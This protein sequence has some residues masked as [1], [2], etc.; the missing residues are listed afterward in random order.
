[1]VKTQTFAKEIFFSPARKQSP[2]VNLHV[3]KR[4]FS[5]LYAKTRAAGKL[6]FV[7]LDQNFEFSGQ[8]QFYDRVLL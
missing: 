3:S 1:M 6:E 8:I 4:Y 2:M 5:F 7:T